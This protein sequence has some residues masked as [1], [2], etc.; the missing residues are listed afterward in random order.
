[1]RE[2]GQGLGHAIQWIDEY[3]KSLRTTFLSNIEGIPS[4]GE[5]LDAQVSEYTYGLANWVRANDSWSFESQR[6]FGRHGLEIQK[7][8]WVDLNCGHEECEDRPA[9]SPI[10]R[11]PEVARSRKDQYPLVG[12]ISASAQVVSSVHAH[13]LVILIWIRYILPF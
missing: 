11:I 5:E 10:T 2:F 13:Y 8:R 1:M 6:Y 12:L 9:E 4:W 3:H 7:G